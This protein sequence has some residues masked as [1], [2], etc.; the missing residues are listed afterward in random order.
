[1]N[2]DRNDNNITNNSKPFDC[3]CQN[4][5]IDKIKF[6]STRVINIDDQLNK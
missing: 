1:M 6:S 4:C 5:K 2:Q 3:G